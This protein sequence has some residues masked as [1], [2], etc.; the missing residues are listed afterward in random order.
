MSTILSFTPELYKGL[1]AF[2]KGAM[3]KAFD[4][5]MWLLDIA[6]R[7][8][9]ECHYPSQTSSSKETVFFIREIMERYH[10]A[11]LILGLI[12]SSLLKIHFISGNLPELFFIIIPNF[13]WPTSHQKNYDKIILSI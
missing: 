9:H 13:L 10:F 3:R 2:A 1:K 8:L 6:R 12:S 7:K 5:I 4:E 11:Y